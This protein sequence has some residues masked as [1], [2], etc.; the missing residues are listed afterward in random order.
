MYF[1]LVAQERVKEEA[2]AAQEIIKIEEADAAAPDGTDAS[3]GIV[4]DDTSEFVRAIQFNPIAT[5]VKAEPIEAKPSAST[6]QDVKMEDADEEMDEMEVED[7]AIKEED[8]EDEGAMLNAIEAAIKA[9]EAAERAEADGAEADVGGT[10]TEQTFSTGMASTLNIL[11][12]SGILAP[13]SASQSERE[14][15]QLQRDLWL[16]DQRHKVAQRELERL[17]GRGANKDQAT[18]EYENRLREQR[19]ARESLEAFKDY[20]PDV[21]IVYYDEF[22][23]T[24]TPKEAWKALS[25]KFHGKG[26]GKMKVEKRLKKIADEKKKEA[27]ISG[28]TPLSMN[29]AFQKRQEMTGQAHFVLSV[30]NR[31]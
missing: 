21:N 25:H 24:L 20:K 27:M 8:E 1:F 4:I 2:E 19:E 15:T 13:P 9:T 10:S 22:G 3:R 6:S 26:S 28:D 17:Q 5:K 31:G 11:R 18:R 12:Q 23:R 29:S 16:A 14:K 30:G 7:V